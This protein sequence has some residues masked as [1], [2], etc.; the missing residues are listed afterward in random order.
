MNRERIFIFYYLFEK[1][2]LLK[3]LSDAFSSSALHP[4]VTSPPESASH[5]QR[6]TGNFL[7]FKSGIDNQIFKSTRLK[8]IN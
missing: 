2:K 1:S 6:H 8:S 4:R 3:F 7:L 5:I